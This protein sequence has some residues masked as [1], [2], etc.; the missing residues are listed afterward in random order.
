[1]WAMEREDEAI[2]LVLT[3]E[4][5]KAERVER[6]VKRV[7]SWRIDAGNMLMVRVKW[8]SSTLNLILGSLPKSPV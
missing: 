2:A 1:M 8:T 5:G 4:A 3:M 7:A 6:S